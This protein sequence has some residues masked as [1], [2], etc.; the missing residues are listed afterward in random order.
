MIF[1]I[2]FNFGI[3]YN[4]LDF[5]FFIFGKHIFNTWTSFDPS[6]ALHS[7]LSHEKRHICHL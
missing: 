2:Q 7:T 6:D 3:T 4:P 1:F 5:P